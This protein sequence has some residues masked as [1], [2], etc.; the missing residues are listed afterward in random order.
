MASALAGTDAHFAYC[1]TKPI[2]P[3]G[4]LVTS[5]GGWQNPKEIEVISVSSLRRMRVLMHQ[6]L[7]AGRRLFV[8]MLLLVHSAASFVSHPNVVLSSWYF[9]CQLFP[10]C[11]VETC[12]T[13]LPPFVPASL[14]AFGF[15]CRYPPEMPAPLPLPDFVAPA[16]AHGMPAD[17]TVLPVQRNL[18]L[19]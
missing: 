3:A 6:Q 1:N 16:L 4:F 15:C 5:P 8:D 19:V 10:I 9:H 14:H 17:G 13:L 2:I 18:G 11:A 12:D 7:V